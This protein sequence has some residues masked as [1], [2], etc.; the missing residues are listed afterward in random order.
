M[1]KSKT[2]RSRDHAKRL[3]PIHSVRRKAAAIQCKHPVGLQFFPQYDQG[4]IGEIHRDIA[5]PF[6]EARDPLEARV[7]RGNQLKSTSQDKLESNFLG[8]PLR[9]NQV[10]RL[11]KDRLCGYDR[12]RPTLERSHAF[13]VPL[14]A[15]IHESYE[16]PRIQ[17]KLIG[18]GVNGGLSSPDV[19]GPNRGYRSQHCRADLEHA[20]LGEPPAEYPSIVPRPR[21]LLPNAF[22]LTAL[23]ISLTWQPNRLVTAWLT[24]VPF[25]L[26]CNA[27]R[28]RNQ[29]QSHVEGSEIQNPK[30]TGGSAE[31]DKSQI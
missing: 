21:A 18:H 20:Q 17:Q 26:Q 10:K 25:A 3:S 19:A 8:L 28:C 30:L 29:F 9:S 14:L 4:G 6:H 16:G 1:A 7:R 27:K 23:P 11:G 31:S 24:D 15:S 13:T 22:A 2:G 12:S 5:V